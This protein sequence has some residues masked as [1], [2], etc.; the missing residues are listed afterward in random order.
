MREARGFTLVE[1]LVVVVIVAVM[2]AGAVLALGVVGRDR[3]LE[4]EAR[5]LA[6]LLVLAREHA[7]LQTREYGLRLTPRGYVFLVFEPRSGQWLPS[8]DEALRARELPDGLRFALVLEG[9]PVV[10][11][12]APGPVTPQPQ[13]AIAS[14]GGY[15]SFE[16]TIERESGG[17]ITLRTAEDGSLASLEQPA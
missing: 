3:V 10:L 7:E 15:S 12:E 8:S 14:S 16:I 2:I 4:N 11:R 6:A 1:M 9:R 5:R 17:R 13:V